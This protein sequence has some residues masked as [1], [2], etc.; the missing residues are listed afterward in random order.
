MNGQFSFLLLGIGV[1]LA[2]LYL[3]LAYLFFR[4]IYRIAIRRGL[5]ARYSAESLS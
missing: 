2:I 3:S 4:F 1:A 5:V